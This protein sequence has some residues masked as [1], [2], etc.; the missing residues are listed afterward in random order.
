[1]ELEK[2][3]PWFGVLA[4]ASYSIVGTWCLYR[5]SRHP[6]GRLPLFGIAAFFLSIA[7]RSG[8][9]VVIHEASQWQW[10]A[11]HYSISVITAGLVLW[12]MWV[13]R[14]YKV[15]VLLLATAVLLGCQAPPRP[16]LS[17]IPA[18]LPSASLSFRS[19]LEVP[20]KNKVSLP[21][22][23]RQTCLSSAEAETLAN[24][25]RTDSRQQRKVLNCH[26]GLVRAAGQRAVDMAVRRYFSHCDPDGLCPNAYATRNGCKLGEGYAPNGNQ[27]ES[28]LAG[29][30]LPSAV[31]ATL[32]ASP[33]HARH[34]LGQIDFFRNQDDYGV[35]FIAYPGSPYQYYTVFMIAKCE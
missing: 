2:W 10:A 13:G 32:T 5:G 34:L 12:E 23:V 21:I 7:I 9:W 14:N 35:A 3:L 27:V 15:V 29:I 19:P 24:L 6:K 1:M 8:I 16:F 20:Q 31:W 28:I 22:Y 18:S 4:T 11:L 33:A 17:P 26:P 30:G 25:L